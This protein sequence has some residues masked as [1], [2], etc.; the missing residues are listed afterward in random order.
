[1][2]LD[3]YVAGKS[4]L[5]RLNPTTKVVFL[6]TTSL[7]ALEIQDPRLNGILLAAL[8]V[9]V[10]Y[11]RIPRYVSLIFVRSGIIVGIALSISWLFFSKVG[12]PLYNLWDGVYI[13]SLAIP[14]TLSMLFRLWALLTSTMIFVVVTKESEFISGLRK[15]KVPYVLCLTFALVL[16]FI[17][18]LVEEY[19]MIREAQMA[20]ALDLEK[21]PL[22]QRMKQFMAIIV[23]WLVI[24]LKRVATLSAAIDSRGFQV[25]GGS[26]RTFFNEPQISVANAII[27]VALLGLFVAVLVLRTWFGYF[28]I[29]PGRL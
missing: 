12:Q 16:R 28:V 15:L 23:P 11:L 10:L 13:Y 22:I 25:T 27:I 26:K 3:F 9:C 19:N 8:L 18:L 2:S 1:L 29:V 21:I 5:H 17:P 6:L 24:S 14:L 4:L 20:R 7:L